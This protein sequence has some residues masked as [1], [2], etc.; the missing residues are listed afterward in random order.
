M[1]TLTEDKLKEMEKEASASIETEVGGPLG[2]C[3]VEEV[4][5]VVGVI[6]TLCLADV[7]RCGRRRKSK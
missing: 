4:W 2:A 7:G 5:P 6:M 3:S 1:C